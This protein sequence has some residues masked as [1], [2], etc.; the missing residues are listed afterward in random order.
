M[1]YYFFTDAEKTQPIV[2]SAGSADTV[3]L[4]ATR[5]AEFNANTHDDPDAGQFNFYGYVDPSLAWTK[6]INYFTASM[7]DAE[8][9]DDLY[10]SNGYNI[11]IGITKT[12]TGTYSLSNTFRVTD[13]D[14]VQ[15]S[16]GIT[17]TYS[18]TGTDDDKTAKII[19]CAFTYTLDGGAVKS[20]VAFI[21]CHLRTPQQ[22][23]P[24]PFMVAYTN[25]LWLSDSFFTLSETDPQGGI[26]QQAEG[27]NGSHTLT[28]GALNVGSASSRSSAM[29]GG[30]INTGTYGTHVYEVSGA[31]Y[32]SFM[33]TIYGKKGGTSFEALWWQFKNFNHDPLSGILSALIIPISAVGSATTAIRLSGQSIPV[34][35]GTCKAVTQRFVE[36]AETTIYIP[37]FHNSYLDYAPYTKISLYLPFVGT[38]SINTN[39]CMRGSISIKYWVDV[40]TG[41]C[42]AYVDCVDWNGY[43]TYYNYSG[44]CGAFIPVSAN[45]AGIS[46]ILSG[47][48]GII[49]GIATVAAG[50]PLGAAGAISGVK[51]IV[52]PMTHEKHMGGFSG[53]AGALGIQYPF[54]VIN[55]PSSAI[56]AGFTGYVGGVSVWSGTVGDFS[57]YTIF[58][59]ADVSAVAGATDAEKAEI[60]SILQGGVYL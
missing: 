18:I 47:S 58:E 6:S 48:A 25:C 7:F 27:G 44:N 53:G 30:G 37:S 49:G 31:A 17:G 46:S 36:T 16:N 21:I 24:V 4:N 56:P 12:G 52:A 38:V 54:V 3:L 26:P 28:G 59:W 2:M 55:R 5:T 35:G 39:E 41:E 40:C 42:V 34:S 19:L 14:G 9:V 45:D 33:Q 11:H 8:T 1:G 60:L 20:G 15:V 57:G 32:D 43:H 51:D 29:G 13:A 50:N 10:T 22:L 23:P